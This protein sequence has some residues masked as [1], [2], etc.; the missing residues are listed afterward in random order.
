MNALVTV[1]KSTV[2]VAVLILLGAGTM[3]EVV[4]IH[5]T[6]LAAC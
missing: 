6:A 3:V 2:V 5:W 1:S 4:P